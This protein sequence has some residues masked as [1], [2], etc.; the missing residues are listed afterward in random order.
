MNYLYIL[1]DIPLHHVTNSRRYPSQYC[2]ELGISNPSTPP[3]QLQYVLTMTLMASSHSSSPHRQPRPARQ[4]IPSREC[5]LLNIATR[6]DPS[7]RQPHPGDKSHIRSAYLGP[8][9]M[10]SSHAPRR[11]RTS[12]LDRR[13]AS[14]RGP[15]HA[16]LDKRE[17]AEQELGT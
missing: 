5:A 17:R 16:A 11:R 12:Q 8:A 2:V 3:C 4:R 13:P 14:H 6:A 7:G 15:Q 10:Y 9:Q 1:T